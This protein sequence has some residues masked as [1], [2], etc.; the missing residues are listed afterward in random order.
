VIEISRKKMAIMACVMWILICIAGYAALDNSKKANEISILKVKIQK[1]N[2][3]NSKK[4]K[5]IEKKY[6]PLKAKKI[7]N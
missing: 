3:E 1:I 5:E 2:Y 4:I 6:S 7:L